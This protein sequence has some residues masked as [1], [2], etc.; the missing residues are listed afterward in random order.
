MIKTSYKLLRMIALLCVSI[1]LSCSNE[2]NQVTTD[3]A[4]PT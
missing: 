2:D 4:N 1:L 3:S